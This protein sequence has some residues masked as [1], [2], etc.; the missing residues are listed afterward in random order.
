MQLTIS[1][2]NI[3]NY[4]TGGDYD[5][6]LGSEKRFDT[7]EQIISENLLDCDVMIFQEIFDV[8]L[9]TKLIPKNFKIQTYQADVKRHQHIVVCYK[10]HFVF[11]DALESGFVLNGSALGYSSSRPAVYGR[12]CEKKTGKALAHIVGVH[13]KSGSEHYRSRALQA[14]VITNYLRMFKPKLP[15]VVT[16]DFNTQ[17]RFSTF[18][19]QDDVHDLSEIFADAG[20]VKIKNP[21]KTFRTSWESHDLDHFWVCSKSIISNE[22]W[23]YDPEEYLQLGDAKKSLNAYYTEVS[24]H[25][26]V[27]VTIKLS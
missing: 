22:S 1:T 3:R 6:R 16:G 20:L 11:E 10:D 15:I 8:A 13:L 7:V 9:F 25:V 17:T 27:K 2:F 23:V 4:G 19:E 26:P 21:L 24:D 5:S 14:E 18:K 12:L